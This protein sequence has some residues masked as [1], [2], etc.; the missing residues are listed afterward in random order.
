MDLVSL[1][2][3]LPLAPVRL[4][5]AVARIL[6]EEAD[7]QLYDPSRVRRELEEIEEEQADG[8]LPD[9]EAEAQKERVVSRLTQ[10]R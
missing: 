2:V 8:Q 5:V 9:D 4:V 1:T 3:G 6:Q 10:R 7:S